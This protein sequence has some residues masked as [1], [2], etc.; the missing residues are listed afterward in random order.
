MDVS[1]RFRL[2][3]EKVYSIKERVL[4]AGRNPYEDFWALRDVAFEIGEGETVGI[5]GRNG[6]GKSTLLKCIS[7]ILQPTEGKVVVRG[8]LAALLEL[9]AGFQAE[10]SGRENIYLNASLLGLSTKDIERRFDEIVAFAELEQFIDN[11]V[12]YYSSG[13]YVR[14]GFAVA[15]NVDPDIL[16]IDEVLAVGD[17]NFQRKCLDR[18]KSFQEDGRTILFVTHAPDLVRQICD[19]AVVLNQGRMVGSGSPGEGVR[20]FREIML[21]SS[22]PL[23][24][25]TTGEPEDGSPEGLPGQSYHEV[26]LTGVD[27]EHPGSG[28]RPYVITGEPLTVHVAFEAARAV[29]DV[30]FVIEIREDAG[31]LIFRSDTEILG[32]HYDAPA[33]SG[34]ADFTFESIP[35]LDGT[36][37]LNVGVRGR[38]GGVIFDWREQKDHFEVM[39]P[40][41]STG[42]I[43]L[44]LRADIRA[45]SLS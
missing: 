12:K 19:S 34:R 18:I 14:L 27:I 31:G 15:V 3:H 6:S 4:R 40:G 10:L 22:G 33:G 29:D 11:Q 44:E 43:A 16:V 20:L 2:Y 35:L 41:R 1:K 9:G 37:D 17:E 24:V 21:E 23:E 5:L 32:Y 13:M 39:N 42:S 38:S 26:L 8:Q 36:Y 7:G 25:T 30:V 28:S 45:A